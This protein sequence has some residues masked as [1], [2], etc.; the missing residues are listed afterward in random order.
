MTVTAVSA[1]PPSAR[2]PGCDGGDASG[3]G[4]AWTLPAEWYASEEIF[5][6]ERATIF[7]RNWMLFSWSAKIPNPGDY[8]RGTVAG[9]SVF[10]IRGDDGKVRAFHNV[11]RH[12]G[13]EMVGE[14]SGHCGKLL[15]CPYHSWGYDRAGLLQRA[16]D[17]GGS[18]TFDPAGWGLHPV[19][20]EEW[21]GFVFLKIERGGETLREWLG[22]IDAMAADYPLEDQHYFMSKDRD[23]A[24][25]WKTY[26][27]NY[28]ECYHCQTMHPGLCASMDIDRYR[29]DVHA[30]EKFFHLHAPAREGGLTR[31]LYFYRFP[32]LML[33]LYDWGSS[34]ATV[35]PIG[36]GKIRH[37]N[38]YFFTDVSPEKAE[39]NRQSAEWSA[40]IVSEDIDIILG[41]QRNLEAGIYTR[42]PISPKYEHGV[43]AFQTMVREALAD[44]AP[45][46]HRVAAE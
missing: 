44:P 31:G 22:A 43:L 6:R 4:H 7:T 40:Q 8:V 46:T 32:V 12:R 14:E 9:Y 30:E 23:V 34:I 39:A 20:A 19:D 5:R 28:L 2:D 24:V 45:E 38:W 35:E 3:G 27:D 18:Q 41:V 25:D 42:G 36:P 33:N 37:I 10:A 1:A 15:V 29:V 26:G 17:F 21:R 11:C 13:A 16:R